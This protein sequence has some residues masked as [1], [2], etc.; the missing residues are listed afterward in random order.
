MK[1][2]IKISILSMLLSILTG[3]LIGNAESA[4]PTLPDV[5][6]RIE[7]TIENTGIIDANIDNC[8]Y[9]E[10]EKEVLNAKLITVR[11]QLKV[12]K[13]EI[14]RVKVFL[15]NTGNT[16]W[17]SV[18]SSCSG[19][20]MSLGLDS[21]RDRESDLRPKTFIKDSNFKTGTRIYMDQDRINPGEI[22][23]FTFYL[24]APNVEDVYKEFFT[25]VIEGKGWIDSARFSFEVF[26]GESEDSMKVIRE[27][28]LLSE[29][30]G[31]VKELDLDADRKIIVDISEQRMYLYLGEKQVR[32]FRV[33]TGK[34]S[35]PTPYG[36]TKITLKQE[37]R[38]GHEYPH[39]V[40]PYFMMFR[41]GGYGFHALPSLGNDGGLFWTEA[42]NHIGIPVSHGCIR[43]LPENAKWL[44]DFIPIST[45][46][47]VRP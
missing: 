25:P 17:F 47:I 38:V 37:V 20:K 40:M 24:E 9:V 34:A 16:P 29:E 44:F 31:S 18:N 6:D 22:A 35:T 41:A 8:Q 23:S 1:N 5:K 7:T 30:S 12:D 3:T 21:P 11:R 36:E 33:S 15:K 39:Y 32:T 28:I 43:I 13:G 4:P 10:P 26:I 46:V 2:I 19:S 27:K 14:F 45:T 42:R